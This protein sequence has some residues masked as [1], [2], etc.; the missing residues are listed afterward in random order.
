MVDS[1]FDG[2]TRDGAPDRWT[3]AALI[4]DAGWSR[5][6]GLAQRVLAREGVDVPVLSDICVVRQ[7]RRLASSS[8]SGSG[9]LLGL[10]RG[11]GG[12]SDRGQVGLTC[13]MD[14]ESVA[15][16]LLPG[17]GVEVE[18]AA[19]GES[20]VRPVVRS[21]AVSTA[22]PGCGRESSRVH[23]SYQRSLADRPVAGRRVLLDL[24]A[25]RLVRSDDGC[26]R[27]TF[28]EQ[29]PTLTRRYARRTNALPTQ[30]T[31]I[32]LFLGGRPGTRLSGRMAV[33]EQELLTPSHS[34]AARPTVTARSVTGSRRVRHTPRSRLRDDPH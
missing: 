12:G 25:R 13:V 2:M 14:V 3:S 16:V 15:D 32:A 1:V 8:S 34:C 5:T 7:L 23:C 19:L 9:S 29:A 33:H 22:C 4:S 24:R 27:R 11:F 6:R 17:V 28:A 10:C 26:A 31:D 30:L 21:L 20:E 18:R